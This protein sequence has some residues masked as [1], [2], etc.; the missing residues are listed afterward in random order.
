MNPAHHGELELRRYRLG[1]LNEAAARGVRSHLESCEVCRGRLAHVDA[2]RRD[3]E[4]RIS[5]DRFA[6]GVERAA[7]GHGSRRRRPPRWLAPAAGVALAA[8][9]LVTFA[10]RGP[11]V[12][13]PPAVRPKGGATVDFYVGGAGSTR[14]AASRELLHAGERVRIAYHA[15]GH[16]Y[17]TVVSIDQDGAVS[18]IYPE[19][20]ESLSTGRGNGVLPDSVALTGTGLERIVV[21]LSDTPL[22]VDAVRAA[23]RRAFRRADGELLSMGPLDLPGAQFA[24]TFIK[25]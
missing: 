18:P 21:V 3:F 25:P 23:A 9:L 8:G 24:R 14:V 16:R 6:A 15:G 10:V 12:P 11:A 13:D 2:E 1:E 17:V 4:A 7:R 19:H 5:F 20:G 22:T